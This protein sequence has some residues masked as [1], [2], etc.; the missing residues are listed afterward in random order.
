[1]KELT[2]SPLTRGVLSQS[3][4][5]EER[6][7]WLICRLNKEK[8]ESISVKCYALEGVQYCA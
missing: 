2:N 3:P 5:D 6:N 1:M 4:S 7:E 8:L